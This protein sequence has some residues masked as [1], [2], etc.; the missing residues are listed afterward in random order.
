MIN[1]D[2]FI[3]NGNF[4]NNLFERKGI[5]SYLNEEI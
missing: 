3:Y 1:N 2:L 4:K 5:M